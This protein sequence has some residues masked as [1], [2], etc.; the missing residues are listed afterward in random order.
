MS[1]KR[2]K[3]AF[4]EMSPSTEAKD[5]ML[6]NL[7]E[8]ATIQEDQQKPEPQASPKKHSAWKIALPLAACLVLLTGVG[9]LTYNTFL[10][11]QLSQ[12][13]QMTGADKNM[14]SEFSEEAAA[15]LPETELSLQYPLVISEEV[16][17][18]YLIDAKNPSQEIADPSLVGNKIDEAIA[19]SEDGSK[20][21]MCTIY[22]YPDE[23]PRYAIQYEGDS[24]FYLAAPFTR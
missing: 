10:K 22:E 1:D 3:Q 23:L 8:H 11:T 9:A 6:A 4:E 20:S 18:L 24:T 7:L 17:R 2:I 16:G 19:T 12:V 14:S 13:A 5:R 21:F 15:P